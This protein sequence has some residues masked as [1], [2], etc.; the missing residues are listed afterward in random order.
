MSLTQSASPFTRLIQENKWGSSLG[1]IVNRLDSDRLWVRSSLEE[2]KYFIF[3][4][5]RYGVEAKSTTSS[6]TT[7]HA[8]GPEISGI[9]GAEYLTTRLPLPTVL[10]AGYNV[11]LKKKLNKQIQF[12]FV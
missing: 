2:I 10:Y 12:N 8:M 5:L 4:F 9:W 11:K 7:Q 1:V 3:S 6:S